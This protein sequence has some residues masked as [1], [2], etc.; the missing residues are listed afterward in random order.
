MMNKQPTSIICINGQWTPYNPALSDP[1]ELDRAIEAYEQLCGSGKI[2]LERQA[3][4]LLVKML[5]G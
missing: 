1:K 5:K 3:L 2:E 4:D